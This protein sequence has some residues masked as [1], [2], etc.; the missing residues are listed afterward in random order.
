MNAATSRRD[1]IDIELD[2][3]VLRVQPGQQVEGRGVRRLVAELRG[4]GCT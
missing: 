4:D 2:D 3:L 1:H